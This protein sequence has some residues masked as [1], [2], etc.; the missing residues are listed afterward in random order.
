MKPERNDTLLLNKVNFREA[1]LILNFQQSSPFLESL[2]SFEPHHM[3]GLTGRALK[4]S[5]I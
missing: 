2:L 4:N 5:N 3:G 1:D